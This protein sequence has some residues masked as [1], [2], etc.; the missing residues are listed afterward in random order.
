MTLIPG[1]GKPTFLGIFN[2]LPPVLPPV[3]LVNMKIE[4][5]WYYSFANWRQALDELF[6]FLYDPSLIDYLQQSKLGDHRRADFDLDINISHQ[7]DVDGYGHRKQ[8]CEDYM[9]HLLT[10]LVSI[11]GVG[12]TVNIEF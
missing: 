1:P 8:E 5:E 7:D 6:S 9:Y 3:L 4:I 2:M 12:V 11:D 10:S